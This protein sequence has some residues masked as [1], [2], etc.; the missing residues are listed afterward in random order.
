MVLRSD[1]KRSDDEDDEAMVTARGQE[2]RGL[3]RCSAGLAR[4]PTDS[5][6]DTGSARHLSRM[7]L[8][9]G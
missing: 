9:S 4:T 1:I 6:P 2:G 5:S 8:W 3:S 7:R